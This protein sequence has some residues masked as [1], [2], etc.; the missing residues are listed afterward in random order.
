MPIGV[1]KRLHFAART[2]Q[3]RHWFEG[4][5]ERKR[6]KA[7]S[8][9]QSARYQE[10]ALRF[11]LEK[12]DEP[13][14]GRFSRNRR[15]AVG[16]NYCCARHRSRFDRISQAG[17]PRRLL[18]LQSEPDAG[19]ALSG[20]N[21]PLL[22]RSTPDSAKASDIRTVAAGE[23]R[24]S[25]TLYPDRGDRISLAQRG[26]PPARP[27]RCH[28]LLSRPIALTLRAARRLSPG[29]PGSESTKRLPNQN[30]PS[31]DR[32]GRC[33]RLLHKNLSARGSCLSIGHTLTGSVSG[34]RGRQRLSGADFLEGKSYPLTCF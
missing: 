1:Q 30:C 6:E 4:Y 24:L 29:F 18:A 5:E 21:L 10:W 22:R 11:V 13:F 3:G 2:L 20:P 26:F 27:G 9:K 19:R 31:Q 15:L 32:T 17:A 28:W 16:R 34:K 25:G 23:W 8:A 7:W 33:S 12:L 14:G